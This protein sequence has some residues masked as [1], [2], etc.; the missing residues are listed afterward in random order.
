M[1]ENSNRNDV[2][3]VDLRDLWN[4]LLG[5][6]WLIVISTLVFGA[7]GFL[8]S[9][10]VITPKYESTTSIYIMS[11]Q[12]SDTLT[13]SDA[14]LSSQLTKDYEKLIT[15]RYVLEQVMTQ[16]GIEEKYEDFADRVSVENETDTRIIEITVKDNDP[17]MAQTLADAIREAAVVHIQEVT[18]VQAVNVAENANLEMEPTEPSVLLWTVLGAIIGAVISAGVV[19]IRF[20]TDDTIK[21]SEDI[22]KYL[23]LSTLALIPDSGSESKKRQKVGKRK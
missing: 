19:V 16:Y 22:E 13:Y 17:Y 2:I 4:V 8:L 12:N 6:L 18:D 9:A 5:K 7:G 23:E 21:T 15:G 3:V 10:F 20:L 14:Q 11:K 1:Q